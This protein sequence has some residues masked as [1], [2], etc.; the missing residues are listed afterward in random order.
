MGDLTLL[1]SYVTT[2]IN[3]GSKK[4][5]IEDCKREFDVI[6]N[7]MNNIKEDKDS[8][9]RFIKINIAIGIIYRL[10]KDNDAFRFIFDDL[11]QFIMEQ[12]KDTIREKV[13][14]KSYD[15]IY[16][17]VKQIGI[18]KVIDNIISVS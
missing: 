6:D 1:I 2:L 14:K 9:S 5:E 17:C 4:M 12:H 3:M 13:S 16:D 7:M 8:K 15:M 18:Y 10:M 11:F